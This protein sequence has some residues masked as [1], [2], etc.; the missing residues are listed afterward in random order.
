MQCSDR[1]AVHQLCPGDL[2]SHTAAC[3]R[4][5]IAQPA[6]ISRRCLLYPLIKDAR[7]EMIYC[8]TADYGGVVCTSI[9]HACYA[10]RKVYHKFVVF[11]IY[12]SGCIAG[13]PDLLRL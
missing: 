6:F 13:M 5:G 10:P 8:M 12:S 1:G 3:F 4:L 2:V 11:V 7:C 9:R